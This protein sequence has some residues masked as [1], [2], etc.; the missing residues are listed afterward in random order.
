ME[1]Y[2][3][4]LKS[5]TINDDNIIEIIYQDKTLI[6]L[7]SAKA[8]FNEFDRITAG[9]KVK[10]LM[11]MG[12]AT[13]LT[14]EAR[15]FIIS[16]NNKRKDQILAEAIV[17]HSFFQKLSANFYILYLRNIYPTHFFTCK[18]TASEWLQRQ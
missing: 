4:I 5:A 15:H 9:R 3:E 12:Q 17:V 14:E 16:E 13:N 18:E 7:E 11:V 8:I 1:L 6:D 10:K 2:T